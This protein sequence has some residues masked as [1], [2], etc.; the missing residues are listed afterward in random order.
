MRRLVLPLLGLLL[1]TPAAAQFGPGGPP[2]SVGVIT[3]HK[4]PVT[5]S[6][7]FV[8]RLQATDHVDIVARVTAA[9]VSREF[10]EGGEVAAGD[11]LYRLERPPFEADLAT[12]QANAAQMAAMLRNATIT[13]GRAQAL[14]NTPAGQRSTVD[15]A[16]AQQASYAAQ[17][18]AAE[19]Q[20]AISQINLGYTEIRAP[21]AGKIGRSAVTPG[22]IVTPSS[23]VLVSVVSQDPMYVLFAVPTRTVDALRN[24]YADRGGFSAVAVRLRL[25]DGRSY[26][27]TG[28]IDYAD[29]SVTQGTDTI[30]LRARLANPLRPAAKPGEPGNRDLVDGAFVT[31]SVEGVQ[32]VQTLA[33]PQ[34]AVSQDQQ[35]AFVYV[36]DAAKKVELRRVRLGA[37][38]GALVVLDGGLNDGETLIVEGLQRVRPG[39]EVAPSPAGAPPGGPAGAPKPQG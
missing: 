23:G 32:P 38:Q 9:L 12:K 1:V 11:L 19:A 35:G 7:E 31:V 37:P 15:D 29:P 21:I 14:L 22:N 10:T 18:K 13:L 26:A 4:Q 2:P 34:A 17:L 6:E 33:I 28:T 20:A 25:P 8:G 27:R 36:V 16:Q 39:I 24:R 3:V 30:M 5:E